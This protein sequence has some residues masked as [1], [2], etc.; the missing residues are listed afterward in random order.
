MLIIN[1][2]VFIT[3][4]VIVSSSIVTL[5]CVSKVKSTY[6]STN[7]R[8]IQF[9][10]NESDLMRTSKI[11]KYNPSTN[12]WY[13]AERLKDGSYI[14]TS[15]GLKKIQQDELESSDEDGGDGANGGGGY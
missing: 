5:S 3:F 8:L 4:F 1:K 7:V 12:F 2:S 13:E 14:F 15:K 10:E 9:Y 11:E 6:L